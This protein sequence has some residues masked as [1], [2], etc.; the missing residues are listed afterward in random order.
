MKLK[1]IRWQ[2]AIRVVILIVLLSLSYA[3]ASHALVEAQ[4]QTD[5]EPQAGNPYTVQFG[6]T[7]AR[8]AAYAYDDGALYVALCAHNELDDCHALRVGLVLDI[9]LL[10]D[11]P[12]ISV[13]ESE[14]PVPQT[15]SKDTPAPAPPSD[16]DPVPAPGPDPVSTPPAPLPEDMYLVQEGDTL[17]SIAFAIYNNTTLAG[18]LCAYNQLSDCANLTP[19]IR[20]FTPLLDELLF[21]MLQTVPVPEDPA[22]VPAPTPLPQPAA[23]Q[24]PKP[25]P[26][27]VPEPAQGPEATPTPAPAPVDFGIPATDPA[28]PLTIDLFV[29]ADPRL[30]IYAYALQLTPVLQLLGLAGPYTL[31]APSDAAWVAADTVTVQN[32]FATVDTL[33]RVLRAHIVAG[34]L[35]YDDLAQRET[36]ISIDGD[37]W[38]IGRAENGHLMVGGSRIQGSRDDLVNGTVHIVSDLIQP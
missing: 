12:G 28:D 22:P 38:P 30:E 16:T 34:N 11:L 33:T 4:T 17:T 26:E 5:A 24:D 31:L 2:I 1:Y 21:G 10:E 23:P 27:A 37:I 35:S 9:P 18:R 13:A 14:S 8:I 7:L 3:I 15:P 25:E 20:I 32:L 36:V 19:G 29:A 6:D